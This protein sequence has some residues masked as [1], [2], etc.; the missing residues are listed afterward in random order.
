MGKKNITMERII[1]F[2][3][4]EHSFLTASPS[5]QKEVKGT[6]QKYYNV[7][8]EYNSDQLTTP[9]WFE[10]M[11]GM[12][13][14]GIT[15]GVNQLSG[16][17]E[18]QIKLNFDTKHRDYPLFR[19]KWAEMYRKASELLYENRL[20]I[21]MKDHNPSSP[22]LFK[23]PLYRPVDDSGQESEGKSPT[24]FLK[25]QTTGMRVAVFRA[26]SGKVIPPNTLVGMKMRFI[27]AIDLSRIFIGQK[28]S[29]QI[30]LISGLV[31]FIMSPAS[32]DPQAETRER[33]L[34][35]NPEIKE[36]IEQQLKELEITSKERLSIENLKL[37]GSTMGA[38]T[39]IPL[40]AQSITPSQAEATRMF[41]SQ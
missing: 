35:E 18:T 11:E 17:Q 32:Y 27:A 40:D 20:K 37:L 6:P 30:N 5:E 24:L 31:T 26:V 38:R 15:V 12:A 2:K 7:T 41:L 28:A 16:K 4:F 10:A 23:D 3:N 29:W 19:A 25:V 36:E 34:K 8:L 22:A 1:P 39:E 9:F 13:Y 33:L 21:K 14:G